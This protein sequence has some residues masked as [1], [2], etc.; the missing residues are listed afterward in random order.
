MRRVGATGV[1]RVVAGHG[2]IRCGSR[3]LAR[4]LGRRRQPQV[5]VLVPTG[6]AR[7][8]R[9]VSI[10]RPLGGTARYGDP[11]H[12]RR[13][14]RRRVP[15]SR[16]PSYS[17]GE[18]QVLQARGRGANSMRHD[19]RRRRGSAAA[20]RGDPASYHRRRSALSPERRR[21]RPIGQR[22]RS[23][24]ELPYDRAGVRTGSTPRANASRWSAATGAESQ[25]GVEPGQ[26]CRSRSAASRP[27]SERRCA[28]GV[29]DEQSR[30]Q[31]T[32]GPRAAR[33]ALR[34]GS[35][36]VAQCGRASA[37]RKHATRRQ[38]TRWSPGSSAIG[39]PC[40]H[41]AALSHTKQSA[42]TTRRSIAARR[43]IESRR[44]GGRRTCCGS[45][46][47]Q[48]A[49]GRRARASRL[50]RD[51]RRR[52]ASPPGEGRVERER[53]GVRRGRR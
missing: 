22:V 45:R 29:V 10:A 25:H 30:S 23:T 34:Y 3:A 36:D 48:P 46:P 7:P 39:A 18:E 28:S 8:P 38:R 43:S 11:D 4:A 12:G 19:V 49:G 44:L 15:A 37:G 47:M 51:A 50:S 21:A 20:G 27:R 52:R 9:T 41:P 40:S 24:P 35:G 17:A 53:E 32:S 5:G 6:D 2:D 31:L 33:F 1:R 13:V 42:G 16:P 14:L 26:S